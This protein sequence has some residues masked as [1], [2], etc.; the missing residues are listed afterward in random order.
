[1]RK[2]IFKYLIPLAVIVLLV[3]GVVLADNYIAKDTVITRLMIQALENWHYKQIRL[4]DEFSLKAFDLYLKRLDPNKRFLLKSDVEELKHYQTKIDDELEKG[5]YGLVKESSAILKKRIKDANDYYQELLK[6]PFDFSEEESFELDPNKRDYCA[7]EDEQ[8]ELWRKT[9]KYRALLYY[10][11]LDGADEKSKSKKTKAPVFRSKLEIQAREKLSLSLK[12]EFKMLLNETNDD[13]LE[14]YLN[15][16]AGSFDPHTTYF[17]PEQAEEFETDLS[18]T[19]EGIG[20][21]LEADGEYVKVNEIVVGSA[22][23]HQG[24][25][26]AGDLI[27]KVGQG[28][29]EPADI[30]YMPLNDVVKQIR[31]KK[32]SEVRLTVKKPDGRILVIP[33]IRDVVVIEEAY[34][35]AAIITNQELRKKF[36]YIDLPSFYWDSR[37]NK[38]RSAA[39]DVRYYLQKLNTQN[40][41]G[42][43]LDLRDNTGGSLDD[44]VALSGLFFRNGPVVQIRN[45]AGHINVLNDPDKDIVYDGPLVVLINSFSASASEIVAAALQDYN[46]AIIIGGPR[47]HGKGTVQVYTDLDSILDRFLTREFSVLKPVGSLKLTTQKYYRITGG[48]TQK[49]GVVADIPLPYVYE[50]LKGEKDLPNALPWDTI[51]ATYFRRWPADYDLKEIKAKSGERVKANPYFKLISEHVQNVMDQQENTSQSLQLTEVF[52]EQQLLRDEAER[53]KNYTTGRTY[54]KAVMIN[55]DFG[56]LKDKHAIDKQN[57]WQKQV[58]ADPYIGEAMYVLEDAVNQ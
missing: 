49:E 11:S 15:A 47:T 8:K 36:G 3:I 7:N 20:A 41:D 43:I 25:L 23:W 52:K 24:E 4:N 58:E 19:L 16:I 35:K 39:K 53:L 6:H 5:N 22:A 42:V 56:Y 13:Q 12:R 10:L 30:S 21:M 46:R 17:L 9:L 14:K 32:G 38:G 55:N 27:M 37:S 1:M 44:A 57:E 31:G 28:R 48:S 2:P 40:V 26:K 33:I 54:L 51:S 34:A 45:G 18:G 50:Y 29:G